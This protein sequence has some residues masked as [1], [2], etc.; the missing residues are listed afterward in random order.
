[1]KKWKKIV[2]AVLLFS[3]PLIGIPVGI[4]LG[5][6]AAIYCAD[7]TNPVICIQEELTRAIET[8]L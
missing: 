1:M 2:L 8:I 5:T 6:H 4:I 7:T 3:Q